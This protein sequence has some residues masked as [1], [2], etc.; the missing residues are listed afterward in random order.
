MFPNP[1]KQNSSG[2]ITI[3][4]LTSGS[5][6]RITDV[7]GRLIHE[8]TSLG[9]QATWPGT[10][11]NGDRVHAGVYLINVSTSDVDQGVTSKILFLQ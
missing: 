10:D 2:P 6:V 3:S 1:V 5:Q 8:T 11:L 4:N 7:N 9:G